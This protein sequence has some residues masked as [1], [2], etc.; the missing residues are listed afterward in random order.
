MSGGRK[1]RRRLESAHEALMSALGELGLTDQARWLLVAQC[2]PAVVGPEIAA[3]TEA[4]GFSRGVLRVKASSAAWQ[5]ELTFL[6]DAI[7]DRLNELVGSKIVTD[8]RVVSGTVRARAAAREPWQD[9]KPDRADRDAARSCGVPIGDDGV[10]AAF[11]ELMARH[12]VASRRGRR[13]PA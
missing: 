3:R 7:R 11:E 8:I 6:K 4:D 5:N 12:L 1:R 9:E 2:W 10:R 13:G